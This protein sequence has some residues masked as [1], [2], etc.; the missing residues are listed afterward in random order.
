MQK[1]WNCGADQFDGSIFCSEC[2]AGLMEQARRET[3]A[4]LGQRTIT[5]DDELPSEPTIVHAPVSE[6]INQVFSLVVL[7]SGQRLLLDT[8]KD[9]IVGRKDDKRGIS[10]DVDLSN[11]G[12]YDAGVSRKHARLSLR[13]GTCMI[14]DLGSA[15]GTFIN[16]RQVPPNQPTAINP[17]DE[18]RLGT[19]LL[20][21]EFRT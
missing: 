14:E 15:N 6:N 21:V 2:G 20:R 10:P 17:G 11:H 8:D 18:L 16:S 1:C 4:S 13:G 7:N 3:T 19:L 12:G 5:S 9:L